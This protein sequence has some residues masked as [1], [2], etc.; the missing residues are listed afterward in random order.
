MYHPLA[1]TAVLTAAL[2]L[3]ACAGTP[4]LKPAV[5]PP[6][7]A[8]TNEA[9]VSSSGTTEP[10]SA[11][12]NPLADP[13]S[14]LA[15]RTIYFDFDRADLRPA[16]RAVVQAHARYLAEHPDAAVHLA[17]HADERGRCA[18]SWSPAAPRPTRSR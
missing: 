12:A 16:D 3:A 7:A 5:D 17:G 10:G 14:L 15:T 8:P 6:A 13:D 11:A 4:P 18:T 2:L 9:V 1:R